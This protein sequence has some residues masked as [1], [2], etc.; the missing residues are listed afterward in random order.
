MKK[1]LFI[2]GNHLAHRCAHVH[3]DLTY[4]S[5]PVGMM[6]G[7]YKSLVKA[8]RDFPL[9]DPVIAWDAGHKRRDEESR[10]G[11][12]KKIVPEAYKENREKNKEDIVRWQI[13]QQW[14]ELRASLKYTIFQQVFKS[15]YEADDIIAAYVLGCNDP[16]IILT[17]DKDYYQLLEPGV[18]LMDPVHGKTMDEKAFF[19]EFGLTDPIQW[20]DVGAL[21]GDTGDNI[22]GVPGVGEGTACKLLAKHGNL[23]NLF[24]ALKEE[25]SAGKE[26]PK[27]HQA[28]LEYEERVMLAQSL[29]RMDFNIPDM[30]ALLPNIG[31]ADKLIE[32][33]EQHAFESLYNSIDN[34]VQ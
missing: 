32:F 11:V 25:L 23:K 16:C 12:R 24:V 30:P 1:Y 6:F 33:F 22:F 7:F 20:V 17:S 18:L 15:G 29:K 10:E 5:K 31:D 27:R 28:I 14:N 19:E 21:A 2:D 9:H 26:M 34:L 3:K 13:D 8:K 4:D